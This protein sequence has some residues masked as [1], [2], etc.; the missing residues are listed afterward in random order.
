MLTAEQIAAA[1]KANLNTMFGLT[2]KA[3][4][5]MEKLVELNIQASKAAMG[6]LTKHKLCWAP[7]TRKNC[8]PYK[9]P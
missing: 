4:E 7:K 5:G 8:W 6:E 3:F 1:Q 2:T 9:H